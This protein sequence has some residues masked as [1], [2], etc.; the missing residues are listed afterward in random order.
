MVSLHRGY[1]NQ[2]ACHFQSVLR[3]SLLAT[4]PL[5]TS[6]LVL[7]YYSSVQ[8]NLAERHP[9]QSLPKFTSCFIVSSRVGI[10]WKA[11]GTGGNKWVSVLCRNNFQVCEPC[12]LLF[13]RGQHNKAAIIPMMKSVILTFGLSFTG[14]LYITT[15]ARLNR[16]LSHCK[17]RHKFYICGSIHTGI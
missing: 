1:S 9:F 16:R 7:L 8:M 10:D 6:A 14:F 11:S 4:S 12:V 13:L 3:P 2:Q 5:L 17:I 15:L